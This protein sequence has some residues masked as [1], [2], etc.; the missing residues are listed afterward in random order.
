[1]AKRRFQPEDAH[2]VRTASAPDLSADGRRVAFVLV[3]TDE[4]ADRLR[5]SIWVVAA[6]GSS[7]ARRFTEGPAD[8]GPRFSPD[9]RW[10]AY[11][12]APGE[13]PEDAHVRLAPVG[14]G[15]PARL[16][17]LPGPVSQLAWSPDSSQ[18]VVVCRVG[19]PDRSDTVSA[20]ERN[21]P[22][23]VRGLAARL[24]GV[25][26]QEG[27]LHLFF[28]VVDGGSVRQLTRG[29][30]DHEDPS[31][32]PDG[33]TIAFA[34]D[35][36]PRRDDR[37]FRGDVWVMPVGGGRPAPERREGQR[38]LPAVLTRRRAGGVRG[39]GVGSVERGRPRVRGPGRRQRPAR[40]R[41]ARARPSDRPVAR[42]TLPDRLDR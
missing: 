24:D 26:W 42:P 12:S 17:E 31:F 4:Q 38:L 35:R 8:R 28:V 2:R 32:S 11:L 37:Q 41:G 9:G 40:A 3:E 27:R 30:Y 23:V 25:G 10:L 19:V 5:T 15:V 29:E 33:A 22:R 18:I 20:A 39:G 16:G 6:D 34:S 13:E 14:G 1:V 21:A 36:H 7:P